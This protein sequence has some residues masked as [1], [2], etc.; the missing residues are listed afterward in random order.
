[1]I[2]LV[3]II[4]KP[5]RSAA[6]RPDAAGTSSTWAMSARRMTPNTNRRNFIL[7]AIRRPAEP[8]A[9]R[10]STV[11]PDGVRPVEADF[12]APE[13]NATISRRPAHSCRQ[14]TRRAGPALRRVR[15][16]GGCRP[17]RGR[18]TQTSVPAPELAA[19]SQPWANASPSSRNA[20][21]V[22][23]GQI[24]VCSTSARRHDVIRLIP[25]RFAIRR[26]MLSPS[27]SCTK[28]GPCGSDPAGT[29]EPENETTVRSARRFRT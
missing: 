8:G 4:S 24:S 7:G 6:Q 21:K 13:G 22:A 28:V 10:Q 1:M 9:A 2:A 11:E 3:S 26:C 17:G 20:T 29:A 23:R 16:H 18:R 15:A 27:G 12:P 19:I 5:P 14:S 25:N